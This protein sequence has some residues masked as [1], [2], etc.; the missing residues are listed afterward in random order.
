MFFE[1]PQFI[2]LLWIWTIVVIIINYHG[3]QNQKPKLIPPRK[4]TLIHWH[5]EMLKS[6]IFEKNDTHVKQ[7]KLIYEGNWHLKKWIC[8][9]TLFVCIHIQQVLK[10]ILYS[11]QQRLSSRQEENERVSV[12]TKEDEGSGWRW[13]K[14]RRKPLA[15][16]KTESPKSSG[17]ILGLGF[18]WFQ[19]LFEKN[20]ISTW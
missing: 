14:Q 15:S 9:D 8:V 11:Y 1:H 13:W 19:N 6:S 4:C 18:G 20:V 3:K 12:G 17:W 5:N 10:E 2:P 16:R 7:T